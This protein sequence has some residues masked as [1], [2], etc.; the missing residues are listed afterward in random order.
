MLA[1]EADEKEM[2][3][4]KPPE[5]VP[6]AVGEEDTHGGPENVE[7]FMKEVEATR[8]GITT[9]EAKVKHDDSDYID[10]IDENEQVW[11]KQPS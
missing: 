2:K 6:S 8:T 7:K 4:R 9:A 5:G 3:G 1:D 10:L 11:T